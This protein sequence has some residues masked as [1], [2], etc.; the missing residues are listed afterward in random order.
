MP[1]RYL[2]RS[3]IVTLPGWSRWLIPPAAWV[4]AAAC[5]GADV[6]DVA[7]QLAGLLAARGL[8]AAALAFNS[9]IETCYRT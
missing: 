8:T 2:R 4:K 9:P 7:H 5:G 6:A 3:R 1:A